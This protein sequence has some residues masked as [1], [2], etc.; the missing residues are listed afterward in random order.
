MYKIILNQYYIE[1]YFIKE[2][3][4]LPGASWMQTAMRLFYRVT[5][6][7]WHVGIKQ[8]SQ[9]CLIKHVGW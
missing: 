4:W 9:N 3:L 2:M 7:L 8:H 6:S 5:A 1:Y